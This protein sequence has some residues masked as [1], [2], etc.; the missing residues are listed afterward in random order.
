MLEE[1][2]PGEVSDQR[3]FSGG[4]SNTQHLPRADK[5]L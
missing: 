4:T 3:M 1:T 5:E 2:A